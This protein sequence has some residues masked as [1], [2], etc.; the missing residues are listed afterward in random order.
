MKWMGIGA[1]SLSIFL[2]II[3]NTI[4]GY[5]GLV[6]AFL[7]L[8]KYNRSVGMAEVYN[9]V[10]RFLKFT[11]HQEITGETNLEAFLAKTNQ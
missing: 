8:R 3:G 7:C 5:I 9:A 4:S 11:L 1:F 6:L 2:F 10:T